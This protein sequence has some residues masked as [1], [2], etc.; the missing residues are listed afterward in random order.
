MFGCDSRGSC[1]ILTLKLAPTQ[2]LNRAMLQRLHFIKPKANLSSTG[3]NS[4]L[5]R[6][7]N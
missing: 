4:G 6:T 3:S 1:E 2:Q 5:D 7:T